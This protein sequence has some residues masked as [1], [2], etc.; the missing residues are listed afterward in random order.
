[1]PTATLKLSGFAAAAAA[2][3]F[4]GTQT[5]NSLLDNEWTNF[6]DEI[7]NLTNLYAFVDLELVLGSAAYTGT[8]SGMEIYLIPT[9]DGTNYPTWTGDVTTDQ[10][11][12]NIFFVGFIPLTGT[13]AAQ[14]GTLLRVALPNGKYRWGVRNRGN[15]TLAATGNTLSWRPHTVTSVS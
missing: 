2:V 4:S 10:Q 9:V 7:D 11:A 14:R 13:T 1:M 8:D 15:V 6:S 5:I 12:N 3:V